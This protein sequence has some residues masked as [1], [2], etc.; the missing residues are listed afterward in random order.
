M[1]VGNFTE[2]VVQRCTVPNDSV[3]PYLTGKVPV[4]KVKVDKR[5]VII[6]I[7]SVIIVPHSQYNVVLSTQYTAVHSVAYKISQLVLVLSELVVDSVRP[8]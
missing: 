3:V 1:L 4:T 2:S 8:I 7:V 6:I 5:T